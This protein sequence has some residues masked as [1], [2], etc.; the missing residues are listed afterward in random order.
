[1][2][3][4]IGLFLI[5]GL[6]SCSD[7]ELS[8][9]QPSTTL[10]EMEA[11]G[12]ETE[13]SFTNGNWQIAEVVNHNSD[14]SIFG[15][16]Y[17]QEGEMTKENS[18]L[19]LEDLGKI[20][21]LWDIKGF[22]ITRNT[23]S[24]LEVILKENS[25]GEEFGFTLVLKSGEEVKEIE[26]FQKK[27][28]GYRFNS[29]IYTLNEDD[30]DSLFVRKG[31]TYTF[32]VPESQ[33]ISISP[34]GGV[35]TH[36]QSH[37]KSPEDGAFIWL[38]NDSLMVEVPTDINQNEIYFNGEERLYS[39]YSSINPHGFEEMQKVAIPKG[40]SAFHIEQEWRKRQVSYRLNLTNNRT[41]N[42]KIIEGKWIETAPTGEYSINWDD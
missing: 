23:P 34:Y 26:V 3:I 5:I 38:K 10:I 6:I 18:V 21:A 20:E 41:G 24:L 29:I 12:G 35:D 9:I 30:G 13:I 19:S 17:S 7:N 4:F 22:V 8:T 37:F 42:E 28:Q 27:S 25:S 33:E 15:N 40:Q 1:M 16:I 14:Y 36:I 31:T 2:K 11:E 32:D 39:E